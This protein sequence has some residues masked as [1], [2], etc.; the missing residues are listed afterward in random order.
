[1]ITGTNYYEA[2]FLNVD[3]ISSKQEKDFV[4]FLLPL[5]SSGISFGECTQPMINK[6]IY[7]EVFTI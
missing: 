7:W 5:L 6:C 1:M 4:S 2:S 3:K